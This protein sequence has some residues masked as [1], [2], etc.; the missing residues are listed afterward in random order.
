MTAVALSTGA[1]TDESLVLGAYNQCSCSIRCAA[2]LQPAMP[3]RAGCAAQPAQARRSGS[4]DKAAQRGKNKKTRTH[5][6]TDHLLR[7]G[8]QFNNACDQK[9]K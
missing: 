8:N 3:W 4:V 9:H 6:K 7:V 2:P 1:E 5:Q